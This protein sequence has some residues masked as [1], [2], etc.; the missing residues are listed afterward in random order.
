MIKSRN[1]WAGHVV[2]TGKLRNACNDLVGNLEGKTQLV[3]PTRK[4][5]NGVK[6]SIRETGFLGVNW[7]YIFEDR[8]GMSFCEHGNEL[9]GFIKG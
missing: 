2:R 3:K 5:E 4:V 9:T 1:R 6:M 7:V 8:D